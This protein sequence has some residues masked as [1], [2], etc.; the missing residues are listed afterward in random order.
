VPINR[1]SFAIAITMLVGCL[2]VGL[3]TALYAVGSQRANSE[4]ARLRLRAPNAA[5]G[6]NKLAAYSFQTGG[7]DP[8]AS[9][10]KMNDGR[11]S[12]SANGTDWCVQ[13]E[14]RRLLATRSLHFDLGADGSLSEVQSC[15]AVVP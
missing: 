2:A 4:I 15:P 9:A 5:V 8:V 12:L 14:I 10:L 3:P 6:R 7:N 11:V 1:R 13:L